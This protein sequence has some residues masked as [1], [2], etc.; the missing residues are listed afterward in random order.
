MKSISF[1][2]LQVYCLTAICTLYPGSAEAAELVG[3][4]PRQAKTIELTDP[5]ACQQLLVTLKDDQTGAQRDVTRDV[6]YETQPAGIVEVSTTGFVTA[7][8]NGSATITARLNEQLTVKFPVEVSS[9][10]KQRPVNFYNDV[11]PQLTRGGCNSGACHGTPSGKNNFHLSLLGFEP[12]NDFEYLTKES[13]GRRVSPAAPET[14]LL[15]RKATGELPHGG[16]S[17]FK[18]GG[19]EYELIKRWI[20]EGMHYNPE[21]S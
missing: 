3:Y 21:T 14:S 20:Q 9:F 6:K 2:L 8:S 7:L 13:L 19:A 4:L 11:I 5:D 18:K 1:I 15:L 16:G 17:R 10:E 12:A